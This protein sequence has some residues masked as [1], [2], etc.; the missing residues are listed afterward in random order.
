MPETVN[1]MIKSLNY[2]N[3]IMAKIEA[4]LAGVSEA[5][6]LNQEGYVAECTGDNIFDQRQDHRHPG[7]LIRRVEGDY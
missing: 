5:I 7:R 4:N 6:M 2:L 3:N 1:P